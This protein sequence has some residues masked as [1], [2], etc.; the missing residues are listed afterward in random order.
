MAM[1][2]TVTITTKRWFIVTILPHKH[3]DDLIGRG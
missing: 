3:P 2:T 1:K